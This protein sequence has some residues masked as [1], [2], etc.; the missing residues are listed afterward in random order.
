MDIDALCVQT[1][2]RCEITSRHSQAAEPHDSM[3]DHSA[4]R[5]CIEPEKWQASMAHR[6]LA[7]RIQI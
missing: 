3:H 5:H 1:A 4:L 7:Y 2:L 6:L